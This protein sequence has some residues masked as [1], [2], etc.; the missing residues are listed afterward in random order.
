[1][2]YVCVAC[3]FEMF[4]V[5]VVALDVGTIVWLLLLV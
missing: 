2:V 5:V 3:C 1:M 4:V